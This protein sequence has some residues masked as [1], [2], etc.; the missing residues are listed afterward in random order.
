MWLDIEQNT[1]EWQAFRLGKVT[2]SGAALFMANYGKAFGEP[3]KRYAEAL[4]LQQVTGLMPASYSNE[5][6]QRGHEQE[7][8]ARALYE[9]ETFQTVKN[10]GFFDYGTHGCSPDGLIEGGAI[11]IKSVLAGAHFATLKRQ[12]YDPAY[13]WQIA[14]QLD[15]EG[16]KFVDFVSYCADFPAEK[17]LL[18]FRVTGA[19]FEIEL[20]QLR[21]RR[22]D[23][24]KLVGENVELLK[25]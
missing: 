1:P 24:L 5:Q 3:A 18:I 7:P 11:E 14:S 4:A 9:A 6:M 19:D 12:S 25:A 22:A 13:K 2:A 8:I 21:E 17:Q 15:C 16:I 20:Q 23:F 10:G